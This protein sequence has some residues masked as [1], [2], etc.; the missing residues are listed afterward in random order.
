MPCIPPKRVLGTWSLRAWER[1]TSAIPPKGSRDLG[2][3]GL[4]GANRVY[5]L[6]V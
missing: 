2:P 3:E 4:G 6:R 1:P 5:G